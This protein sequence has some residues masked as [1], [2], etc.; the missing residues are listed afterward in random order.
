MELRSLNTVQIQ[1]RTEAPQKSLV[2]LEL[3]TAFHIGNNTHIWLPSLETVSYRRW[4]APQ[5]LATHRLALDKSQDKGHILCRDPSQPQHCFPESPISLVD[6][7]APRRLRLRLFRFSFAS[8]ENP[9]QWA[10]NHPQS[11]RVWNQDF[12]ISVFLTIWE[13]YSCIPDRR[14]HNAQGTGL[15]QSLRNMDGLLQ[16]LI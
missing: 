15:L 5:F 14:H 2:S 6:L 3:D 9:N 1:A 16:L 13:S 12:L 10:K 11:I 7:G 8:F 4:D